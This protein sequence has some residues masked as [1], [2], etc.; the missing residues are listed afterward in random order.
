MREDPRLL[1]PVCR[2]M[3]AWAADGTMS[4]Y[5][6]K[7][8]RALLSG[9]LEE[10]LSVLSDP[11]EDAAALRQASPFVGIISA[12]RRWE[13]WRAIREEHQREPS[14]IGTCDSRRRDDQ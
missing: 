11:G 13:I 7:R 1:G 12:R 2:R 10:L 5:Y 3:E 9:P 6:A 4:S 8:W 14:P